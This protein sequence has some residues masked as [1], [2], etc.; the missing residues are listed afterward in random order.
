MIAPLEN[1]DLT[2]IF[3]N[4]Y[5]IFERDALKDSWLHSTL[6]SIKIPKLKIIYRIFPNFL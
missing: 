5:V 1:L 2:H 3:A 6:I 4:F